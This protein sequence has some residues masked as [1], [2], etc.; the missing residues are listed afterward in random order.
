MKKI[1]LLVIGLCLCLALF[2][3]CGKKT[4]KCEINMD[5]RMQGYGTMRGTYN[6][7]FDKDG[8][9]SDVEVVMDVQFT[10]SDI[11]DD[12]MQAAKTYLEQYCNS[13]FKS[14]GDCT[15]KVKGKSMQLSVSGNIKEIAGSSNKTK[16][17]AKEYFEKS[18]FTC[19]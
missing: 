18:G 11:T 12:D 17:E 6:I 5:S 2:T 7:A 14:L 15:V 1:G 13:T 19:N 9:A 8:Y 16:E 10:G 4:L 3:G